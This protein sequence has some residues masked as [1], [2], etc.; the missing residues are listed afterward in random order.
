MQCF[1]SFAK[2]P[3]QYQD[4]ETLRGMS[5]LFCIVQMNL[6]SLTNNSLLDEKEKEEVKE[7]LTRYNKLKT[8]YISNEMNSNAWRSEEQCYNQGKDEIVRIQDNILQSF[9]IAQ[10][11]Y[12]QG[13]ISIPII[14]ARQCS[15]SYRQVNGNKQF[16]NK[17][18]GMDIIREI[19]QNFFN[20]R[21]N[22]YMIEWR[23]PK[24][25]SEG[26]LLATNKLWSKIDGEESTCFVAV[27]DEN[28]WHL[29]P[30]QL[31][32]KEIVVEKERIPPYSE[33]KSQVDEA[34]CRNIADPRIPSPVGVKCIYNYK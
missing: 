28:G 19:N 17:S 10:T 14:N 12:K 23:L 24:K 33:S 22:L 21:R 6:G 25:V 9:N 7:L 26:T 8:I 1:S 32:K 15:G 34:R 20:I 3:F 11:D 31:E 2:D 18:F 16:I 27:K 29:E 13:R 5:N 30:L 4:E